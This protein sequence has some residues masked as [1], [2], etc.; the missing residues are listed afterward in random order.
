LAAGLDIGAVE[1]ARAQVELERHLAVGPDG[2]CRTC[3][4]VEPCQG[5][6]RDGRVFARYGLL[7]KRRPGVTKLGLRRID[8]IQ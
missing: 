5:R 3:G 7:P 1:L 6:I 2:R 4:G 8:L